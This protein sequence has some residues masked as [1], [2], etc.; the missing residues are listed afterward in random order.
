MQIV[1]MRLKHMT[2]YQTKFW[3]HVK[4]QIFLKA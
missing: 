1:E 2:S 3:N 4:L